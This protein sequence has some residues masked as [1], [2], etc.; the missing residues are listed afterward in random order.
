MPVVRRIWH[1]GMRAVTA[2]LWPQAA[3]VRQLL[4]HTGAGTHLRGITREHPDG[5][6]CEMVGQAK[7]SSRFGHYLDRSKMTKIGRSCS[8]LMND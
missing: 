4:A 7:M 8:P 6:H 1:D 3:R 2:L 5:S